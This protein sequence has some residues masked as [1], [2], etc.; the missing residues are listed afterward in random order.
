M[1][2]KRKPA[3][4]MDETLRLHPDWIDG[5]KEFEEKG[6]CAFII[7]AHMRLTPEELKARLESQTKKA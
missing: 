6:V 4:S 5:N 2:E 7:P 1:T 3:L